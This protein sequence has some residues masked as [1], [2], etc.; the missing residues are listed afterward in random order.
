MGWLRIFLRRGF[1]AN[2]TDRFGDQP[3]R[4]LLRKSDLQISYILEPNAASEKKIGLKKLSLNSI[5]S[6]PVEKTASQNGG[7]CSASLL[8]ILD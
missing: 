8:G 2:K 1:I 6:D 4:I 5:E 3:L 7:W